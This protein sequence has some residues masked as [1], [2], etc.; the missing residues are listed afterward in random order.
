MIFDFHSRIRIITL[1]YLVSLCAI[2]DIRGKGHVC[3]RP[4]SQI[5]RVFVRTIS[6]FDIVYGSGDGNSVIS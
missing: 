1:I 6:V 5:I 2:E 4:D 3:C